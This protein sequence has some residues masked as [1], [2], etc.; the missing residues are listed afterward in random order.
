LDNGSPANGEYDIIFDLYN[1]ESAVDP[2]NLLDSVTKTNVL[3]TNGL[4]NVPDLDFGLSTLGNETWIEI[5][6]KKS[7]EPG[8][9]ETLSAR[10][11]I[12]A[13]PYAHESEFANTASLANHATTASTAVTINANGAV[14]N[15]VLTFDGNQWVPSANRWQQQ[16]NVLS[17]VL[18]DVGIQVAIG[19]TTTTSTAKL[20]VQSL[21]D[22]ITTQFK[23]LNG[24]FNEYL[25]NGVP[26]GYIGS[27][28]N[29]SINGT[30]SDDFEIGT[31]VA[32][33]GNL[34]LTIQAQPKL[35][36]TP[37][38]SVG[39][40]TTI[41][42]AKF[43][44][45]SESNINQSFAVLNDLVE[46]FTVHQNGGSSIGFGAVPPTDGLYLQGDSVQFHSSNGQMKYLVR[47]VCLESGSSI[48]SFYNGT[49]TGGSVSA[50]DLG[51]VGRCGINFPSNINTRYWQASAV[52]VN[53][54]HN[55]NCHTLVSNSQLI[56]QRTLSSANN[57]GDIMILVY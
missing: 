10:Q 25:E 52:S 48:T 34:H 45:N 57:N 5:S 37:S 46:K 27:V 31:A 4:F 53:G 41:P 11:R 2:L 18:N 26:R 47:A 19:T 17:T 40:G 42:N 7:S 16:N 24:M 6:V 22:G 15:D 38:G 30:S 32:N 13:V 50:T 8:N 36:I 35:T 28:Q 44:V 1:D 33:Q 9:F 43:E 39:V 20:T 49:N 12:N 23:G 14:F 21:I 56:C 54:N 3:V 55:V 51:V 29:G